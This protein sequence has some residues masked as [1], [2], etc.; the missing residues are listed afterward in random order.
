LCVAENTNFVF[1]RQPDEIFFSKRIR[2]MKAGQNFRSCAGLKVN[3]LLQKEN[4]SI[5]EFPGLK[6]M[7]F[8]GFIA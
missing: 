5:F 8:S 3:T 4:S 1:R 6:M 2:Q 7:L